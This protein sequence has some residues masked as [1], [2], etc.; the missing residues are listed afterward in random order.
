MRGEPPHE[1]EKGGE[2]GNQ[3]AHLEKTLWKIMIH[4]GEEASLFI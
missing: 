3:N 4:Q 1:G 2:R